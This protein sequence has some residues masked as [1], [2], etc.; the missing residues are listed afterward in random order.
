MFAPGTFS[1]ILI[2]IAKLLSRNVCELIP[3]RKYERALFLGLHWPWVLH[4]YSNLYQTNRQKDT[5]L[6][7]YLDISIFFLNCSIMFP[8]SFLWLIFTKYQ[9]WWFWVPPCKKVMQ[10][11][12]RW[13]RVQLLDQLHKFRIFNLIAILNMEREYDKNRKLWCGIKAYSHAYS[14]G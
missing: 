11:Y 3:H 14:E 7:F 1:K 12:T 5:L 6:L 8:M 10:R 13:H 4:A 9:P 2:S